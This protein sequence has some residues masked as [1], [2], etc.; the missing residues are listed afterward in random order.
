MITTQA[1]HVTAETQLL[2]AVIT[3]ILGSVLSMGREVGIGRYKM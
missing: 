1:L 2:D 3:V